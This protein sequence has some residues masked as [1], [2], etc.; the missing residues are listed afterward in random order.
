MKSS[1]GIL[2]QDIGYQIKAKIPAHAGKLIN[3]LSVVVLDLEPVFTGEA[4]LLLC[5]RGY[6]T[7]YPKK[8]QN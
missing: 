4:K 8:L 5:L 7:S 3:I 6:C 1:F 2:L